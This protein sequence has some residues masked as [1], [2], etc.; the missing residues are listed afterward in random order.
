MVWSVSTQVSR[1][2]LVSFF[3]ATS[4]IYILSLFAG[5]DASSG[6]LLSFNTETHDIHDYGDSYLTGLWSG[7]T[8]GFAQWNDMLYGIYID[9]S[10]TDSRI[11]TFNLSSGIEVSAAISIPITWSLGSHKSCLA[12]LDDTLFVI[13]MLIRG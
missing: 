11:N 12:V 2:R 7:R 5:S 4:S 9:T 13:G 1:Q 8:Q 6:Q 10:T 3:R